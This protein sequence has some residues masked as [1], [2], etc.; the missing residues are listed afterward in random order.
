MNIIS[1]SNKKLLI[2]LLTLSCLLFFSGRSISSP[3]VMESGGQYLNGA[4]LFEEFY[5]GQCGGPSNFEDCKLQL[6]SFIDLDTKDTGAV[7][8]K[9]TKYNKELGALIEKYKAEHMA[10]YLAVLER[11]GIK[12]QKGTGMK[13]VRG[14]GG[15][16]VLSGLMPGSD[17][18]M[19]NM[20]PD[21]GGPMPGMGGGAPD[22][23]GPGSDQR[24][25]KKDTRVYK[26]MP[27]GEKVDV[28][29]SAEQPNQPD[30]LFSYAG[31]L[32]FGTVMRYQFEY[33]KKYASRY[34]YKNYG[35]QMDK[36]DRTKKMVSNTYQM[37]AKSLEK[38]ISRGVFSGGTDEVSLNFFYMRSI[39][40]MRVN[41]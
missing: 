29:F 16:D 3:A 30:E 6:G 40:G 5:P 11:S 7:L 15:M 25:G 26:Y 8:Y 38:M 22:M 33:I 31:S 27:P 32:L 20:G 24:R 21:M 17:G 4:G 19:Q 1:I 9:D 28:L 37:P 34:A 41:Y 18:P 14:K 23:K 35:K 39:M 10:N 12:R 2:A 36:I 13:G